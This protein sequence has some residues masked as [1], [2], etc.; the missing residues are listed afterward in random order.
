MVAGVGL[1]WLAALGVVA[2]VAVWLLWPHPTPAQVKTMPPLPRSWPTTLQLGMSSGPDEAAQMQSTA[3]FGFRYQYLAGG[4]NTGNGWASWNK[5]GSFV[6]DYARD[7]NQHGML[8]VFTYYM[9]TQS[10]PGRG[11]GPNEPEAVQA[12]VSNADTM[13][14]YF[15]DLRLFF[16]RAGA[17]NGR[18]VVL[19]VE[20]DL[21]GFLQRNARTD[22]ATRIPIVVGSTGLP[23]LAG[24]PDTLGGFA[25]AIVRLRDRAAPNVL[26]GYH[27]SAW[28]TGQDLFISNATDSTVDDV[29]LREA[30]FYSS[31]GADFDVAFAE[32]SDRDAAFKQN[33]YGDK[34]RSWWNADDFTRHV[35]FLS[36]FVDL[37]GKRI[38]LWQIPYGNTRM[39]AMNNTWNHFQDTRVEWLL[40]DPGREHLNQYLD[41]GVIAL[42]FG[43]GA[44]GA[45]NASDSAGDGI[46]DPPPINGNN[47][48]SLNADDDGGYFRERAAAYYRE[49]ALALP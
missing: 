37:T 23:E 33:I 6:T 8:P 41:A 22:D 46:T 47:R 28:G 43:R 31:L 24:L 9:L 34:G 2:G 49:G 29:A 16:Q 19:H 40:D 12:N 4:V 25:Q 20:P 13:R 10:A 27:V 11:N 35:R 15:L 18:P 38:V 1:L 14:A 5:D 30:T 44:D 39:Q 3:A 26:L 42:L 32:F 7:S 21:W 36:R 17:L 48:P 45:T